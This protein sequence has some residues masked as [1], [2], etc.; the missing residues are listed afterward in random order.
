MDEQ[1]RRKFKAQVTHLDF[2]LKN[3]KLLDKDELHT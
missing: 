2:D 3:P 1:E